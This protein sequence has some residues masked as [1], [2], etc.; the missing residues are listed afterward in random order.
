MDLLNVKDN[1]EKSSKEHQIEIL[2]ILIENKVMV[3]E[4][5]NG[6]F[7]NLSNIKNEIIVKI[8]EYLNY[9]TEQEKTLDT[10]EN[11]KKKY[12]NTFFNNE[13][14]KDNKTISI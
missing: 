12:Q 9:I 5:S 2:R 1:I 8:Q 11:T 10:F 3:N 14:S 6:I 4:N 7:V 13:L